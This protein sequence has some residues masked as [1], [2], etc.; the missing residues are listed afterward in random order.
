MSGWAALGCFLILA[1]LLALPGR[2]LVRH[3]LPVLW[4]S[5]VTPPP[6]QENL[7]A[8]LLPAVRLALRDLKGQP[9]P[10]GRYEIH[11]ELLDSQCDGS[12]GLKALF[13]AMWTGPKYLMVFGGACHA[14]TSLI[15]RSLQALDLVQLSFAAPAPGLSDRRRFPNFFST[16]PSDRAVNRAV[17]ELLRS[18]SWSRVALLTQ[19]DQTPTETKTDLVRQLRKADV[20]IIA[21]DVLSE[22]PCAKLKQL[23]DR[24]A[25]ILVGLLQGGAA[26]QVF[27]CAYR[28]N[29]FGQR[30]Q[31]ILTSGPSGRWTLDSQVAACSADRLVTAM[32][33]SFRL[34]VRH[35]SDGHTRG[36]SGRTP[37]EYEE[38]YLTELRGEGAKPT[39]LHGFTYD[40][41]WVM[42]NALS[43]V[44][45]SVRH[46][47]RYGLHPNLT[48]T[49][50]TEMER[51]VL[52]AMKQTH[53]NG[54]TGPVQFWNGERAASVELSQ[55]QGA[56]E[57]EVGQYNTSTQE[58]HLITDRMKF[59]GETPARD[60]T[61]VS[62][63][64]RHIDLI[65]YGV[66]SSVTTLT[67]IITLTVLL[68]SI[69]H[70]KHWYVSSQ[71]STAS[72]SNPRLVK[73]SGW[74]LDELLLLGMLL[75][76]S[77][78]LLSGLDGSLVS[79]PTFDL[80][81]SVRLWSLSVGHTIGFGALFAKTWR[82]YSP[83]TKTSAEE[84]SRLEG[85]GRVVAAMLLL[86]GFVLASWQILDPLRRVVFEHSLETDIGGSD[87]SVRPYS[88][89]CA[90]TNLDLWLTVVYGYKGA[91]MGL[92]CFLAWNIRGRQEEHPAG[93]GKHLLRSV[94]AVTLSSIFG[95]LSSL[96]TSSHPQLQFCS[97]ALPIVLC[98]CFILASMFCPK[99]LYIRSGLGQ[100]AEF[101]S[102]FQEQS[103]A[104]PK[105][106]ASGTVQQLIHQNQLLQ[107]HLEQVL[108]SNSICL[109]L[110]GEIEAISLQLNQTSASS[111]ER[112]LH[113]NSDRS[114]VE[115]KSS[116]R[117]THEA[118]ISAENRNSRVET[119]RLED[120]NSPDHV[121]RRFSLQLPILHHAY[122]PVIGG[123]S[124]SPSSLY[125]I[126]EVAVAEQ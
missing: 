60:R 52:D 92:G 125:S 47:E 61:F 21:T 18:F 83:F 12:K 122:L 16:V 37:E 97:T 33:G 22:D 38:A 71:T 67:I 118:Q 54:V 85:P 9:P 88:E 63:Q 25:R 116:T 109:Q 15:A 57:V 89:H 69:R 103:C 76:S 80:L 107:T 81:C 70:H 20:Q 19:E 11:F 124:A 120:I 29:M 8:S 44:M 98:N 13:D 68:F 64:P 90:S 40:G 99:V 72:F 43:R 100:T 32:E 108:E 24:D 23:K 105:D 53:F 96:L 123:V 50:A 35:L 78:V 3:P 102:S 106:D 104:G 91:V 4:V 55:F 42:A 26:S 46:R 94:C 1:W 95:V 93:D 56:R 111:D 14:M 66:M 119:H 17:V 30:Y 110:D 112:K 77:S 45:E 10:L 49:T 79:E 62:L 2:S 5:P 74:P 84:K 51:M 48:S 75:S 82:M 6:G 41:V 39:E 114:H 31:W 115:I 7:T 87:V 117:E 28:L 126:S 113:H 73:A 34:S 86:D 58:L 27:C 101:Q 121:R 65:S 59:K 36:I